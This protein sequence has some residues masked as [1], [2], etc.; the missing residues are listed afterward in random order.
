M[1]PMFSIFFAYSECKTMASSVDDLARLK[2]VLLANAVEVD[3]G[4]ITSL[5]DLHANDHQ[6]VDFVLMDL[7]NMLDKTL[8]AGVHNWFRVKTA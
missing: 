2:D 1:F 8:F 5:L 7:Q 3:E 4:I 6:R